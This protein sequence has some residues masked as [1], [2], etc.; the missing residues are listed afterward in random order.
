MIVYKRNGCT[1]PSV[2][3]KYSLTNTEYGQA[4][5]FFIGS[6]VWLAHLDYHVWSVVRFLT[7]KQSCG[8]HVHKRY[9]D[10]QK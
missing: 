5:D 8:K 4:S 2:I 1:S 10:T 3:F 9:D 6:I 7:K